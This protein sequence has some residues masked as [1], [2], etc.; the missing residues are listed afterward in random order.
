MV[1]YS[2][3]IDGSHRRRNDEFVDDC[4]ARTIDIKRELQQNAFWVYNDIIHYNF[5]RGMGPAFINAR[6]D[7][8]L[9]K[10]D[11]EWKT[12][13]INQLIPIAA[14]YLRVNSNLDEFDQRKPSAFKS[15][16]RLPDTN[17]DQDRKKRIMTAIGNGTFKILDFL[18][19]VPLQ[20]I[21]WWLTNYYF[22]WRTD[23]PIST[24]VR[25][26]WPNQRFTPFPTTLVFVVCSVLFSW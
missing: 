16:T 18:H 10:L 13:D 8:E 17:K 9:G 20:H 11:S 5:I 19:E 14:K 3:L 21:F 2:N 25:Y 1:R 6:H 12:K 24:A 26:E 23:H 22:M 15:T 4:A 7:L